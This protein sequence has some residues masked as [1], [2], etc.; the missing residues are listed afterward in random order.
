MILCLREREVQ[1][2]QPYHTDTTQKKCLWKKKLQVRKTGFQKSTWKQS[3]LQSSWKGQM[4]AFHPQLVW[5]I[6]S[7][8][9]EAHNAF[10]PPISEVSD[11]R[12]SASEKT[13][14]DLLLAN[15]GVLFH[16]YMS[17]QAV[18]VSVIITTYSVAPF[19]FH[20]LCSIKQPAA[21][22][23]RL[24]WSSNRQPLDFRV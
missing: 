6:L 3:L 10:F 17:A 9:A 19:R 8:N 20:H 18:I 16:S 7:L 2:S 24:P 12:H 22:S 4:L 5:P 23:S 21:G 1:C 15:C 14:T 11:R 13:Y